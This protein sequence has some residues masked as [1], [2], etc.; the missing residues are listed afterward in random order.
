VRICGELINQLFRHTASTP[1][2]HAKV[3]EIGGASGSI[4]ICIVRS[5]DRMRREGRVLDAA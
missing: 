4:K 3:L 5:L 2:G 1:S